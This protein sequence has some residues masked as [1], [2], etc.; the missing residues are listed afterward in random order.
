LVRGDDWVNQ[1]TSTK[2]T[3]RVTAKRI[4]WCRDD[5]RLG[6]QGRLNGSNDQLFLSI[7]WRISMQVRV[8]DLQRF[9]QRIE[10]PAGCTVAQLRHVLRE[11][12]GFDSASSTFIH[13]RVLLPDDKV[14]TPSDIEASDTIV[15]FSD[16]EFPERSFP[17][18]RQ[19]IT[20][21]ASRFERNYIRGDYEAPPL[22]GPVKAAAAPE[23][24]IF[25]RGFTAHDRDICRAM[26]EARPL[27][28]ELVIDHYIQA[29]RD[30]DRALALISAAVGP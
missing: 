27:A 8:C 30:L 28:L 11:S 10:V 20:V 21:P 5:L 15:S 7:V 24:D 9:D 16:R 2:T 17:S 13:N 26:A 1:T 25:P 12:F 3:C 29:D 23:R 22:R 6:G 4:Q 19:A 14:I 18:A